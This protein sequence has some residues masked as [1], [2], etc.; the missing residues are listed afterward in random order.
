MFRSGMHNFTLIHSG[1]A[2]ITFT[3]DASVEIQVL[4]VYSIRACCSVTQM[5]YSSVIVRKVS[6]DVLG[7]RQV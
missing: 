6:Q 3:C 7:T 1:K 4:S 5:D 2:A